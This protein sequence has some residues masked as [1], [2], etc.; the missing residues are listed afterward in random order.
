MFQE[1]LALLLQILMLLNMLFAIV[2][3]FYERRNPSTTW[4]WLMVL[5]F[6]PW[7]GFIFY[8]LFGRDSKKQR[9]FAKKAKEDMKLYESFGQSY[10]DELALQKELLTEKKNLLTNEMPLG[11][12]LISLNLLNAQ[13]FLS[14]KNKVKLFHEGNAKFESLLNDI[15]NAKSFIH[16]Q[17]YIIRNDELGKRV[18]DALTEKAK[19]GVEVRLLFDG[20]GCNEIKKRFY[21]EF[22]RAGGLVGIFFPPLAIRLNYRNHRKLCIIDG[23]IAYIGGFNIGNEY[24]GK[25]KRFG[26]W[27]DTHMKV[28]GN[29]VKQLEIRFIMDWNFV[30]KEK[31]AVEYK[32]FPETKL[33]DYVQMQII[34]SGPDTNMPN[35]QFAYFKMINSAEKSIYIATPY[36]I[37]DGGI[38]ESLRIAALSGIDV[39]IIIPAKPDHPFV[40]GAN[41]SY[42]GELLKVGVKCY[43]YE[44]GFV[45]SK[46]MMI[47]GKTCSVGTANMDVRSFFLNFEVNAIIYNE[48]VTAELEREFLND[49]AECTQ[50]DAN[51]YAKRPKFLKLKE[52]I[53]RLISPLL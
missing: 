17:Y 37:P 20:M 10:Q 5:F 41:I 8:L 30:S 50:I 42:L 23:Q 27:R 6:V 36:F 28:E 3:V 2:V 4:A 31:I 14:G 51:W 13:S 40:Y 39:R 22:V 12:N 49:L 21:R 48:D 52:S 11:E 43:T 1:A 26:F 24:I 19:E 33:M 15:Q 46:I 34:S 38:L 45:H 47:D 53:S 7:F 25:S 18:I 32:Y 44:K 9:I 35:I 29:A 16:I